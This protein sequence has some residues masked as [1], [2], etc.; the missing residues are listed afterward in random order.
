M[1][2]TVQQPTCII[3][4]ISDLQAGTEALVVEVVLQA[5]LGARVA[6]L[7]VWAELQAQGALSA[8]ACRAGTAPA[9]KAGCSLP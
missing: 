1:A 9:C 4:S 7:H 2:P 3:C 5:V 8:M 6:R